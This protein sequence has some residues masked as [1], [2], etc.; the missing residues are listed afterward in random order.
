MG[1]RTDTIS[2]T[3]TADAN[4][5][6][7]RIVPSPVRAASPTVGRVTDPL[8]GFPPTRDDL[9]HAAI[10]RNQVAL[11]TLFTELSEKVDRIMTDLTALTAAVAAETSVDQS[12][13]AL[14][15]NLA[16]Q[17]TAAAG[18]P[19]QVAALAEQLTASTAALQAAVTANT[20]AA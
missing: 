19:A 7:P 9:I 1:E 12:V 5:D 2:A 17:I 8:A 10:L 14:V 13:L 4:A 3:T 15:Q 20:P 6:T 16:A 11:H 18:D